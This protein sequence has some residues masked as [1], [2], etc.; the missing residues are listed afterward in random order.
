MGDSLARN[1][2]QKEQNKPLER[3]RLIIWNTSKFWIFFL[4]KFM[5]ER[6]DNLSDGWKHL[7]HI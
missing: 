5:H 6:K 7:Q 2:E 4:P 1:K 3:K